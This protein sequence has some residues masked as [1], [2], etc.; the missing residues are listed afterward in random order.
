MKK[1]RKPDAARQLAG[2]ALLCAALLFFLAAPYG[3][4]AEITLDAAREYALKNAE[5]ARIAKDQAQALAAT[6]KEASA[7]ARPQ[8]GASAGY[9]EL[10]TNQEKITNPMLD[11][12]NPP[13]RDISAGL[14]VSQVL[15]AGKRVWNSFKLEKNLGL[16]AGFLETSGLRDLKKDVRDAFDTVLYSQAA[17]KVMEDRLGQRNK[18]YNDAR[19]LHEAGMV[20]SL[21]VRQAKQN[22]NFTLDALE[23]AQASL[24]GAVIDFNLV[25]GRSGT[26]DLLVPKGDLKDGGKAD[27]LVKDLEQA[28]QDGAFLDIKSASARADGAT[29]NHQIEKGAYYPELALVGTGKTSGDDTSDMNESWSG[30]V[31]LQY[32]F[33]DGG[34][35]RAKTA[36]SRAE[37]RQAKDALAKTRKNFSGVV[38]KFCVNLD[39]VEKRIVLQAEAVQLA[40]ANYEDASGQYRA[41]TITL[42]RLGDFSLNWA[43]SRFNLIRLYFAR[44]QLVASAEALLD[45]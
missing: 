28:D 30:G 25:L 9:M 10:G 6:G 32:D 29:I 7:F 24:K 20:T 21:D 41:G 45:R 8:L 14:E 13:D 27:A 15:F 16:Q 42:T 18:E 38:Q 3:R 26:E 12:L 22:R 19:D 17:L 43:E 36:R 4:A 35:R 34:Q 31:L 44:R 23:A 2:R 40:E 39:S 5:S 37:M 1:S 33:L 11:F